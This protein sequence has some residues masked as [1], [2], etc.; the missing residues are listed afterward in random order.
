MR[1]DARTILGAVLAGAP[2]AACEE[3]VARATLASELLP[4]PREDVVFRVFWSDG[5]G[6]LGFADLASDDHLVIGRH[7]SVDV[8]LTDPSVA[9]RHVLLRVSRDT[10][11]ADGPYRASERVSLLAHDLLTEH[12]FRVG[13]EQT[14]SRAAKVE[15]ATVLTIGMHLLVVL[16][17]NA[18]PLDA[19]TADESSLR[20]RVIDAD[21]ALARSIPSSRS[22]LAVRTQMDAMSRTIVRPHQATLPVE[23]LPPSETPFARLALRGPSGRVVVPIGPRD[24]EAPVLVG[25]YPRCRRGELAPFSERVSRVHAAVVR[26]GDSIRVIDL[27]STNGLST[28]TRDGGSVR[29]RAIRVTSR[30]SI[31]LGGRHDRI[32]VEMLGT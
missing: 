11:R 9:L 15:G 21:P 27:G 3:L 2:R 23:I 7:S 16:P 25:R 12:G 4:P 29:A 28:Q 32:D 22:E 14:L 5:R 1:S 24:L 20:A 30:A 13:L 6:D 8:R 17:T 18:S 31:S 19:Q 10:T 26:E